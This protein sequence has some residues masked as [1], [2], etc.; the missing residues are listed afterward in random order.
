MRE[1]SAYILFTV[2]LFTSLLIDGVFIWLSISLTGIIN[3]SYTT[4]KI[5]TTPEIVITLFMTLTIMAS[6]LLSF[7]FKIKYSAFF[8]KKINNK[9]SEFLSEKETSV[10]DFEQD[11]NPGLTPSTYAF[12]RLNRIMGLVTG[13]LLCA[14]IELIQTGLS[15]L[16]EVDILVYFSFC[17]LY[18]VSEWW[19]YKE[20]PKRM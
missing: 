12:I 11:S 17:I 1:N 8:G 4:E 6:R 9:Q 2:Y 7:Y 10:L 3:A 14:N 15:I 16:K 13:I 18:G 19:F 5:F 20:V